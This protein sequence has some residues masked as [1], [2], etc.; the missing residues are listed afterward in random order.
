MKV[1]P[2]IDILGNEV[3]RLKF[4][5]PN[6]KKVYGKLETFLKLFSDNGIQRIHLV[7]LDAAFGVENNSLLDIIKDYNHIKFQIGGGLRSFQLIENY[8]M[9]TT[10]DLVLGSFL[11]KELNFSK[12]AKIILDDL[13]LDRIIAAFDVAWITD[14][15]I[16]KDNAWRDS[17]GESITNWVERFSKFKFQS[18]L[19][20]DIGRDGAMMGPNV[21]LYQDLKNQFKAQ[22]FIASGGVRNASDLEQLR[23][24][25]I[26]KVV[27]GRSFYEGQLTIE[28]ISSCQV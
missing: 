7:N 23:Q 17:T 6:S 16:V 5:D 24:N 11:T 4:G 10:A 3:V 14:Q 20:T 1:I 13:P 25:L 8:L 19:V 15:Y 27:V 18:T 26:E 28:E 2:S 22:S 9:K 12:D 21:K